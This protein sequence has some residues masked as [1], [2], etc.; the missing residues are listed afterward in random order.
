MKKILATVGISIGFA[1][2]S[3]APVKAATPVNKVAGFVQS[4]N[5]D[6]IEL[7]LANGECEQFTLQPGVVA[8]ANLRPG[9]LVTLD[10]DKNNT[11]TKIDAPVAEQTISGVISTIDADSVTLN[12]P[13]NETYTTSI[14]VET[15]VRMN[16]APGS[17]LLVTTYQGI[18]TVRICPGAIL[19][20]PAPPQP[21]IV[22]EVPP[23]PVVVPPPPVRALW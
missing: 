9:S 13:N 8:A 1:I 6:T 20:Q 22:R 14:P 23:P 7:R 16:L 4:V 3:A 18:P 5:G 17:P 19:P 2:L 12:L 15:I 21:P 10:T 11:V